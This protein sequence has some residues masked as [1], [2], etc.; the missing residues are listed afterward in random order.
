[1][2]RTF[3]KHSGRANSSIFTSL[4]LESQT[5]GRLWGGELR[6]DTKN[7]CVANY[8]LH[9]WGRFSSRNVPGGEERG[10]TDVLAGYEFL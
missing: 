2:A 1:M 10:E 6:D 8:A 3:Q 7:G 4:L 5:N 9:R